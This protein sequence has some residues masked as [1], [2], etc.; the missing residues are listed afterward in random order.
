VKRSTIEYTGKD[1]VWGQRAS[2]QL[3]GLD[4]II[5]DEQSRVQ[6]KVNSRFQLAAAY[7][8]KEKEPIRRPSRW[9]RP[10]PVGGGGPPTGGGGGIVE[11]AIS[12]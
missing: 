8:L 7:N 12:N 1:A 2:E 6:V 3:R 11:P 9:R 4:K 10:S 5:E